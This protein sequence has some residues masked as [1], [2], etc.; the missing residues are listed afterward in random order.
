MRKALEALVAI[1]A[2]DSFVIDEDSVK[3]KKNPTPTQQRHLDSK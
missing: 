2:I 1:G 3:I